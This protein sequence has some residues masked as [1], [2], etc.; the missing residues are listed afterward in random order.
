MRTVFPPFIL[1]FLPSSS[2]TY[3]IL[4]FP[5]VILLSTM[6]L[7]LFEKHVSFCVFFLQNA[8]ILFLPPS[9]SS[10]S[11]SLAFLVYFV[12]RLEPRTVRA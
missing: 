10:S 7:F 3:K 1:I 9:S 12:S 6:P 5:Y 8:F 4:S 11:V 2:K